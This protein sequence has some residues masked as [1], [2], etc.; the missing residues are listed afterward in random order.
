[1]NN[2]PIGIFDSGIGGLSVLREICCALPN[3]NF[4]YVADSGA[5]PYGDR[6]DAFI[7]ARAQAM[8]EFLLSK[9][10]KAVVVACNTATAVAI[11]TLRAR[12]NLVIV[13]MEPAGNPVM[14]NP[15]PRNCG[16]ASL[17]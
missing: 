7:A 9:N 8:V 10:V 4:L 16:A 2:A 5:A 11:Q 6:P 1:M 3:E 17:K 12:Y 13:A 15:W 14:C